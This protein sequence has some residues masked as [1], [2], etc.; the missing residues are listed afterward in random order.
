MKPD[1]SENVAKMADMFQRQ[2]EAEKLPLFVI[3]GAPASGKSLFG[4]ALAEDGTETAYVDLQPGDW[5]ETARPHLRDHLSSFAS[6]F[7]VDGAERANPESLTETVEQELG[8]GNTLVLLVP[9]LTD[10]PKDLLTQAAVARMDRLSVTQVFK[11]HA[12]GTL[13]SFG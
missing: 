10:I 9:M 6:T 13:R 3:V 4:R 12:N 7:I 1:Q 2:R 5:R 11:H 8:K